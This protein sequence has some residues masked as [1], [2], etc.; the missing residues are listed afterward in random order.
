MVREATYEEKKKYLS[1]YFMLRK[2]ELNYDIELKVLD[3]MTHI[4][5]QSITGMP[6]AHDNRDLSDT[7]VSIE[8]K[9]EKYM[10]LR[11]DADK[12]AIRIMENINKMH[13]ED[14]KRILLRRHILFWPWKKLC[15]AE[16]YSRGGMDKR[17]K[18]AVEEFSH[19][20]VVKE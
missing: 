7:M 2:K 12:A 10:K 17:Y 6:K 4:S 16:T 14:S 19:R 3:E 5:G 20:I 1:S 9:K 15:E 13:D 11:L 18:K 8:E